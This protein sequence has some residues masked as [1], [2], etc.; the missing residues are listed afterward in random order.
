M[1]TRRVWDGSILSQPRLPKPEIDPLRDGA[2][3]IFFF[4][5]T[6]PRPDSPQTPYIVPTPISFSHF[7]QSP[8]HHFLPPNRGEPPL[9]FSLTYSPFSHRP[10]QKNTTKILDFFFF[11][12]EV[13]ALSQYLSATASMATQVKNVDTN[14]YSS[15]KCRVK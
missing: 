7:S 5:E 14:G 9:Y 11:L 13:E 10:F 15:K 4:W 8:L 2:G 1:E 6:R 3:L 12:E